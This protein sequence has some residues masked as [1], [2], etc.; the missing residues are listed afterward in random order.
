MNFSRVSRRFAAV[1]TAVALGLGGNLVTAPKANAAGWSPQTIAACSQMYTAST[2]CNIDV[3]YGSS[4]NA[5][6][7]QRINITGRIGVNKSVSL[8]A[9]ELRYDANYTKVIGFKAAGP[10]VTLKANAQG[11]LTGS[12]PTSPLTAGS[13]GGKIFIVQPADI[14]ANQVT[15]TGELYVLPTISGDISVFELNSARGRVVSTKEYNAGTSSSYFKTIVSY[16]IPGQTY[17]MQAY[18]AGRWQNVGLKTVTN[19]GVV[20]TSNSAQIDWSIPAAWSTG[21]WSLRVIN[22]TKNIV[23]RNTT[24]AVYYKPTGKVWG[25]RDGNNRADLLTIDQNSRL[26]AYLTRG[27]GRTGQGFQ[28]ASGSWA[29]ITWMHTLPDMNGNGW[30]ELLARKSDGTLWI[31][32]GTDFDTYDAGRQVGRGWNGMRVM[33][34]SPDM[35]RDGAPEMLAIDSGGLMW[36]YKITLT[37]LTRVKQMGHGWGSTR[38]IIG[39]GDMTRDGRPDIVAVRNDGWLWRYPVNSAGTITA[40]QKV[41]PGWGGFNAVFSPGDVTGDGRRDL[42]GRKTD[43]TVALYPVTSAGW[44]AT[45]ATIMTGAGSLRFLS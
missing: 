31:Y 20:A 33:T 16:A 43:G 26:R 44:F 22:V 39:L 30:G 37:S 10:A 13:W 25:D 12:V 36:R 27:T 18:H 24:T 35:D 34:L 19:N 23:V 40:S 17:Q 15:S 8:R 28:L 38:F 41:G 2:T 45:P 3:T 5:I 4:L 6:E 11:Y 9:W 7:G 29:S 14:G 32:K 1:V 21:Q 42:V